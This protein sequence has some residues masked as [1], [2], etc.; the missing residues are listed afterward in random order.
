MLNI[1]QEVLCSCAIDNTVVKAQGKGHTEATTISP[2]LT[3]GFSAMRPVPRIAT[4][5]KLITGVKN[6]PPAEPMFV[7]EIVLP[8]SSSETI[9]L[10][11]HEEQDH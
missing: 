1:V 9:C 2:F 3:T 5:G 11:V 10:R 4:S 7:I 8:L 6:I